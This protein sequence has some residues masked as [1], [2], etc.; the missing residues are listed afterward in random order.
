MS[1]DIKTVQCD[2]TLVTFEADGKL[3][4]TFE[5]S[6]KLFNRGTIGRLIDSL[7]D[8]TNGAGEPDRDHRWDRGFD[9]GRETKDLGRF[10]S[11]QSGI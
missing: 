1:F 11:N 2:L 10:Q 6:T 8:L 9:P 3:I 5:Y 7:T 4:N